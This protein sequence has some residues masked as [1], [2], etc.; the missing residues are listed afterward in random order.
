[1][2]HKLRFM[3]SWLDEFL[4][5]CQ[6][7]NL[8][9][10]TILWYRERLEKVLAFL[11]GEG[12]QDIHQVTPAQIRAFAVHEQARGVKPRSVNGCLRSLKAMLN[13]FIGQDVLT[14]SPMKVCASCA[15][16]RR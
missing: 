6:S 14:A 10:A 13:Y 16:R 15:S 4:I 11:E 5:R 7:E 2:V 3:Q 1:M 12:A 9:P 8:S